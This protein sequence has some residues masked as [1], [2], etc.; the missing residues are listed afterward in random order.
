M[1]NNCKVSGTILGNT[2]KS[3]LSGTLSQ[4]TIQDLTASS[5]TLKT[6][7]LSPAEHQMVQEAYRKGINYIFIVYTPLIGLCFLLSLLVRDHG[8]AEKDA[9]AAERKAAMGKSD[10]KKADEKDAAQLQ[11]QE[12]VGTSAAATTANEKL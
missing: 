9:T 5:Y 7:N 4:S 6:L 10:E 3:Q 11:T 12:E 8:V 1:A 2:L